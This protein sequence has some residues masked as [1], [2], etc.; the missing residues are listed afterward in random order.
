[1]QGLNKMIHLLGV[2]AES[3]RPVTDGFVLLDYVPLAVSFFNN[4][5]II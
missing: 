4:Y 5:L 3:M 1:M 2:P